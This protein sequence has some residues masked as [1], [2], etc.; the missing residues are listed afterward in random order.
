M[1]L[2]VWPTLAGRPVRD[3]ELRQ[4]RLVQFYHIFP[5]SEAELAAWHARYAAAVRAFAASRPD[6]VLIDVGERFDAVGRD[7]RLDLFT[8]HAHLTP[9]GN[10]LFA[11]A[12]HRAL[13]GCCP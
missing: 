5:L 11:D 1:G 12:V 7:E 4:R 6:I 10:E 8:D 13:A 3:E 2:V 9:R